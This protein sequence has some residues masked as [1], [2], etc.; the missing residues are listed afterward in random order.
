MGFRD[1]KRALV[2]RLPN[3]RGKRVMTSTVLVA[4]QVNA[5][6]KDAEFIVHERLGQARLLWENDSN[7]IARGTLDPIDTWVVLPTTRLLEE[8]L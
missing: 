4:F 2:S 8:S 3:Y 7:D 6:G 1:R 5:E